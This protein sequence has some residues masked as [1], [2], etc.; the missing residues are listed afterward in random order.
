[1]NKLV[2]LQMR[3]DSNSIALVISPL[4]ALMR[5]QRRALLQLNIKCH[6]IEPFEEMSQ[7]DINGGENPKVLSLQLS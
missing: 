4:K 3:G 5:D 1:M 2:F 7:E 6:I